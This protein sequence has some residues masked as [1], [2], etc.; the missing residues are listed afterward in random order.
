MDK[1]QVF[2]SPQRRLATHSGHGVQDLPGHVEPF[3]DLIVAEYLPERGRILDLG[4]AGFRFALPVALLGR[5]LMVVDPDPRGVDLDSIVTRVNANDGSLL[6]SRDL[7]EL[8]DIRIADGLDFLVEQSA[9]FSLIT[10]FR[11]AHLF[12]PDQIS[13]FF[14]LTAGA[15]EPAGYLAVSGMT[16][17]NLPTDDEMEHN[18]VFENSAPIEIGQPLYR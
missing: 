3:V 13:R 4:G 9:R 16:A 18:E 6:V 8:I 1:A 17:H 15:L 14:R 10:S 7:A 2:V 5:S 12:S 11:V